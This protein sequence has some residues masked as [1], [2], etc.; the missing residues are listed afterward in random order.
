MSEIV[1]VI[2]KDFDE[3]TYYLKRI[4]VELA[5][6]K[7]GS[8]DQLWYDVNDS[9]GWEGHEIVYQ[10]EKEARDAL[11]K[12]VGEDFGYLS[13]LMNQIQSGEFFVEDL[14]GEDVQKDV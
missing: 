3:G 9:Y 14:V 10:T 1:Y 11:W 7:P 2:G 4:R 8:T 13:R 5:P 12:L 6:A